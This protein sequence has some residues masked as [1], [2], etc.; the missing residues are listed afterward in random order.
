MIGGDH[1][2]CEPQI[3]VLL[4][5][6]AGLEQRRPIEA[7][8]AIQQYGVCRELRAAKVASTKFNGGAVL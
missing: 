2:R 5:S 7:D 8:Q 6:L 1:S 4:V 3:D